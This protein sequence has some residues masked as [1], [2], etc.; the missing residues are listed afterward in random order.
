MR[1]LVTL[2]LIFLFGILFLF[3]GSASFNAP[4]T[5]GE[6][7]VRQQNEISASHSVSEDTERQPNRVESA[8]FHQEETLSGRTYLIIIQC[9]MIEYQHLGNE[10]TIQHLYQ[11]LEIDNGD[12][13]TLT[14]T[15]VEIETIITDE[16][17]IPD[18]GS[19]C[20]VLDVELDMRTVSETITIRVD[21]NGGTRFP[22]AYA[23]W[24]ITYT[25]TP[26]MP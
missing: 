7:S 11:N 19:K 20:V 9:E 18:V 16:E 4:L 15:Q 5:R 25:L 24:K 6:K 1:T 22:D 23:V 21:E 8:A 12:V 14:G 26:Y 3:A 2:I 17:E 13:L 10:I